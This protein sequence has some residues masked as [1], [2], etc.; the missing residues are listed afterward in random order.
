V[1]PR[2]AHWVD[3]APGMYVQDRDAKT[4]RVEDRRGDNFLLQDRHGER[5]VVAP[6]GSS[7]VTVLEP[8]EQEALATVGGEVFAVYDPLGITCPPL[9]HGLAFIHSHMFVL[10]GVWTATGPGS[11]SKTPLLEAH[12]NDHGDPASHG[13]VKH[14]HVAR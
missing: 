14:R 6:Q 5:T 10:H 7:A 9:A 4:W 3:I 8:T 13:Y 12:R 2:Q 11:K 1:T